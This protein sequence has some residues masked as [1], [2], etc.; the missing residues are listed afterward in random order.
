MVL[1]VRK[2]STVAELSVPL[3]KFARRLLVVPDPEG[4]SDLPK[5]LDVLRAPGQE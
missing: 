2:K 5:V 4:P 1:D 3:S